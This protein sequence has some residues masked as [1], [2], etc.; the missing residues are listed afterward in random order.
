MSDNTAFCCTLVSVCLMLVWIMLCL[1]RCET[2]STEAREKT[3]QEAMRLGYSQ[4]PTTG[5]WRKP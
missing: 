4:E 5:A 3:K 2:T 1:S